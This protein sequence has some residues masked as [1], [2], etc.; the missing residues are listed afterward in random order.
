MQPT[1]ISMTSVEYYVR[2]CLRFLRYIHILR[3]L[4]HWCRHLACTT[5]GAG[6]RSRGIRSSIRTG[7]PSFLASLLSSGQDEAVQG[8]PTSGLFA[9]LQLLP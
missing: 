3:L 2:I 4:I 1:Y 7:Q 8:T 6:Y 5:S 9:P